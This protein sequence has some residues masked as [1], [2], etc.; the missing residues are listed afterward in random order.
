M[1]SK[2]KY[3][4]NQTKQEWLT[5]RKSGRDLGTAIFIFYKEEDDSYETEY[6]QDVTY[7]ECMNSKQIDSAFMLQWVPHT[8]AS[9]EELTA[10]WPCSCEHCSGH[11][12]DKE[13]EWSH[14]RPDYP[15]WFFIE[16]NE[17]FNFLFSC[18]AKLS[19]NIF[20]Y[21]TREC[22]RRLPAYRVR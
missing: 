11:C 4:K 10:P 2:W 16:N 9:Y 13:P 21:K 18:F 20:R 5:A 1:T 14:D 22:S 19:S 7:Y 17:N 8:V 15:G 3:R 6:L 12:D